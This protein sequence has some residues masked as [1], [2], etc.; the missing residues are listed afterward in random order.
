M[1]VFLYCLAFLLFATPVVAGAGAQKTADP[2]TRDAVRLW[3]EGFRKEAIEAG[4]SGNFFD[5]AFAGFEPLP[6][7]ISAA[8]YQP[9]LIKP[10]EDYVSLLV[11]DIRIG[12]GRARL[13]KHIGLLEN[14]E[15]AYGVDRYILLAIW[16]IESNYG[17]NVGG[18]NVIHALATLAIEGARAKFARKQ[19]LA[20]L[21]VLEK[22][23][24]PI[25]VSGSWAGAMGQM[26]FI[27]TSYADYAVDHDQDGKRDIWN[28]VSD[29]LGSAANYLK[30]FGWVPG[31]FWGVE[32]RLPEGFDMSEYDSAL[33][34][35]IKE[36]HDA[37][38]V[39]AAKDARAKIWDEHKARLL[40]PGKTKGPAF[41]VTKNFD[42]LLKY[43]HAD[44]YALAVGHL[45]DR[46]RGADAFATAWRAKPKLQKISTD[47]TR[48]EIRT[49][50]RL[51]KQLGFDAGAVDGL[52]GK[53]TKSALRLW[54][55]KAGLKS[56]G[57]LSLS[58][59]NHMS[60]AGLVLSRAEVKLLQ[61]RLAGL[62][63]E[64]GPADGLMGRQTRGALRLWQE[65][66]GLPVDGHPDRAILAA[67]G[68][69]LETSA[70]PQNQ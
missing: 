30:R 70:E 32:I 39:L 44:I 36:W 53:R 17:D 33:S 63:F 20:L 48:D 43:N 16:G 54:Q 38:Y 35:P 18:Y 25:D 40:L 55:E 24:F 67:L 21:P 57:I 45:S 15:R 51:L 46:L 10:P 27:P 66:S 29:S 9:E 1:R 11:S 50:Q 58:V 13:A 34:R 2:F 61:E 28:N 6:R 5:R 8:N 42:V 22:E 56:D 68:A 59:L 4:V 37:G 12:A 23:E 69:R 47:L 26:Q 41:L 19:L 3:L 14:L 7:V 62:G 65:R 49:A 31:L 52:W 64:P 60:A